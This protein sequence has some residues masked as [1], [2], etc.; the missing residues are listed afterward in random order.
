[1]LT[2]TWPLEPRRKKVSYWK[3]TNGDKSVA[4]AHEDR[5]LF[6]QE[7]WRQNWFYSNVDLDDDEKNSGHAG[8]QQGY[9]NRRVRPLR[10]WGEGRNTVSLSD[11]QEGFRCTAYLKRRASNR[12]NWLFEKN[13][14]SGGLHS[15][16]WATPRFPHSQFASEFPGCFGDV[17]NEK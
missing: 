3:V 7:N 1:M 14:V 10:D 17:P 9:P 4:A 16:I 11:V 15:Q 8:Y 2:I 13:Q 12:P 5:N 6:C